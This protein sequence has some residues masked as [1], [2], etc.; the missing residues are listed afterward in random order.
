MNNSP[1]VV[2]DFD[3]TLVDSNGIK[4]NAYYEVLKDIPGHRKWI[5]NILD[6][7]NSGD[8]HAVFAAFCRAVGLPQERCHDLISSYSTFTEREITICPMMKGAES[9]LETLAAKKVPMFVSSGT[10]RNALAKLLSLRGLEQYFIDCYGAPTDKADNLR[11]IM[12]RTDAEAERIFVVGDGE[13][14]AISADTIGCPFVPVFG[15]SG[16]ERETPSLN[17]L[18]ELLGILFSL[19]PGNHGQ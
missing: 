9:T 3:G 19:K 7:P 15:F 2:F 8:R 10:P 18:R 1:I 13:V 12:S 4:R 6:D 11:D 5:D 16:S 17:D 14:D